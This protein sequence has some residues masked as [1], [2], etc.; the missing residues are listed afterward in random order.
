MWKDMM[1]IIITKI[2]TISSNS[3]LN[4]SLLTL[5][6]HR[7]YACWG[8]GGKIWGDSEKSDQREGGG[9]KEQTEGK[10][11]YLKKNPQPCFL[12]DSMVFHRATQMVK[13]NRL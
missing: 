4:L 2:F 7:F 8:G 1:P 6:G 10:F 12:K 5:H 9:V 13:G 3:S 11:R